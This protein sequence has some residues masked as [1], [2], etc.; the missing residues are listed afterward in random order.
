MAKKQNNAL[1]NLINALSKSEKRHF[2]MYV[3]RNFG[4]KEIKFLHPFLHP[5]IS[6]FKTQNQIILYH[7]F[8]GRL[9]IEVR[10]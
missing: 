9:K 8:T 10:K 4:D 2:K 1:F 6:F 5:V 3:Q 7:R